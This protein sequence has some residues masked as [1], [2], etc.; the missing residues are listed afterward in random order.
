MFKIYAKLG[1]EYE[2]AGYCFTDTFPQKEFE[3]DSEAQ[4]RSFRITMTQRFPDVPYE[5]HEVS[6]D[7]KILRVLT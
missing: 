2:D 1:P 4:A 6:G 7:G 3:T 5:V